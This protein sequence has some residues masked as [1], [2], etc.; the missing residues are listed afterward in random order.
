[1]KM[2][3]RWYGEDDPVTLEKIRQIPGMKGI[4]SAIY[5][6]PVGE[7]WPLERILKLKETV[8]NAGLELSVIES[9]PVHEDIK[10][11]TGDRDR[12][13]ENYC[14]TLRNLAKAG[15][16]C[17]CY[18]FMPVFDWTRSD[19]AYNLPDG[20][21][22][23][24]YDEETVLKMD[25]ASGELSLPGWDSSY[26]KDEM[27]SLLDYYKN[28]SEE[29]LWNNLKYFLDRVIKV[30]EEVKI[31]M[32]IHPDDP[33]WSIFGLPRI[34]TNKANIERFLK[35]Y[36]SPYNGLTLCSGSLGA[37][38]KND[39]ADLV[40][41]FAD[42][43]HFAHI[44]NIKITGEKCFEEAAHLS[45]EGSLDIYE[46]VKAY[47]EKGF[48]GY[49]RPDHGRMVWGETGKPGYGLFDRA[50][51]AAYLNGLFEAVEKELKK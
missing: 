18:N 13:I 6:I 43:I 38:P 47:C 24:M 30:A 51:G 39:I 42:R 20:S 12:Y 45:S 3:F 28:I 9:V 48:D 37:D 16:D 25:P 1:M 31:K 44:R 10:M 21:N 2:T 41:T 36:D 7:A 14:E 27:K 29:D 17:V 32:A 49:V 33:P 46:I 15:I 35:L 50:L 40:R 5:D 26:T 8:E 11:G 34:I 23:L 22:A 4:V 19:L